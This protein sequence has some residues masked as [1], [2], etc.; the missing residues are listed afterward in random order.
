MSHH[1]HG[2]AT[3]FAPAAGATSAR[4]D[5]ILSYYPSETAAVKA[6]LGRLL[7]HGRLGGTGRLVILPV[8]QGFEHGPHR[9]F[10]VNPAG[11]DPE[12]HPRFALA[13]GM[14]GYAAPLGF[15]EA[16][17]GNYAS[18]LPLIL[19]LNNHDLLWSD[20]DPIPA[21]TG[22]VEAALRLGCV[23]IGYTI[24]PG[25][26]NRQEMYENLQFLAEEAKSAGLAVVVWSYPRGSGIDDKAGETA[27]DVCAYA[28]HLA[29]QMGAHVVKVKLP[30]DHL[31]QDKAKK[32]YEELDIPRS[33]VADRVRHVVQ[34]AFDGKRIVI[35]SGGS[36]TG[37]EAF[38]DDIRGIRD[39]GGFGSI[40]G[41]NTF[42]RPWE[43]SLEFIGRV[44]DIYRDEA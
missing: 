3:A 33:T 12:Y 23:A 42:Q 31:F 29:C 4:V 5:E 30:S 22:S 24:Y 40:I 41:R 38:F 43:E 18:H 39:G 1:D 14:S 16:V 44:I 27:L 35:F 26:A 25:S 17:A 34:A 6:S 13:A 15:I 19:K 32:V 28:A 9:S 36:K 8:D 37:A 20:D 2:T 10:A 21:V 7:Q 11:Y